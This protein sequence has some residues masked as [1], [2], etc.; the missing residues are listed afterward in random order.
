M[1]LQIAKIEGFDKDCNFRV[2]LDNEELLVKNLQFKIPR[3]GVISLE[4]S[5]NKIIQGGVLFSTDLLQTSSY[6]YIPLY[7]PAVYI[8]NFSLEIGPPRVL[9]TQPS[10]SLETSIVSSRCDTFC[11]EESIDSTKNSKNEIMDRQNNSLKTDIDYLRKVIVNEKNIHQAKIED[12]QTYIEV[13]STRNLMALKNKDTVI[14]DIQSQ[15]EYT[16]ITPLYKTNENQEALGILFRKIEQDAKNIN[17]LTCS[18][19]ELLMRIAELEQKNREI[20]S[21]YVKQKIQMKFIGLQEST[22]RK[23]IEAKNV[24]DKLAEGK[25]SEK[26]LDKNNFQCKL[27]EYQ[28]VSLS[29]KEKCEYTEQYYKILKDCFLDKDFS[30]T[31]SVTY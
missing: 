14:K 30:Q 17:E 10:V 27:E 21:R 4:V 24:F 13:V 16:I 15:K 5:V 3:N 11:L 25:I 23:E 20:K 2:M 7:Y 1:E 12:L 22:L 8:D 29:L 31:L 26:L 18:K 28:R 19:N 9:V 6:Q